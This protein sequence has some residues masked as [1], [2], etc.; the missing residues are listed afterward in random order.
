MAKRSTSS[1]SSPPDLDK[2]MSLVRKRHGE[3]AVMPLGG[4][5]QATASTF[6]TGSM[7]LDRALGGGGLP[8]GRIIEIYGPE[9]SGKT[10][11]AL[12]AV[13]EVQRAGGTAAFI[14]AEHALDPVYAEALGV[15][16]HRV[17]ISQPDCG[18]QALDIAELMASSG[19]VQ[20]VIVDSVAALTPRAEIEGEM[21]DHHVG[22]QARMMSKGLRKITAA[23]H[24]NGTAIFFINQLRQKIGVS[25]G[26]PE[27]TTGGRALRFY[28]SV[29][30]DIRRIA[31][32]KGSDGAAFG[33]RTRVKVAKNKLAPPFRQAEFDV[34]YG[35]G[36]CAA[37]EVLD[38]GLEHGLISKA[39]T[40][41]SS[42]SERLG[43]GRERARSALLA[44]PARLADLQARVRQSWAE[45]EAAAQIR[46]P[47]ARRGQVAP[48]EGASA[49]AAA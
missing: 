22:L 2:L 4:G 21:G 5:P 40:W 6:P 41:L 26:S 43:Q 35:R 8:F 37:G 24:R 46:G 12:H 34:L 11:L 14:D 45:A 19:A 23:A 7:L 29:R 13:A 3:G 17:L 16:L 18:E 20:L 44:D 25:F 33:N 47:R 27:T 10:T 36:I 1:S 30:L 49:R 39:G 9:S 38:A 15:D 48:E 32:L 31:T 42:G 28:A